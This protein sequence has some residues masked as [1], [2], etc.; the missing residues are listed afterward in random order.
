MQQPFLCLFIQYMPK[1]NEFANKVKNSSHV[2]TSTHDTG[3]ENVFA[4]AKVLGTIPEGTFKLNPKYQYCIVNAVGN[5]LDHEL[6]PIRIKDGD[7]LL[8]HE[9]PLDE[10][11]LLSTVRKVV[12][13]VLTD[14]RCFV[15]QMVFYDGISNGIRVR[16]FNPEEERFFVPI[17]KIKALFVVDEALSAE[18][19]NQL[20]KPIAGK[21]G[22]LGND[23]VEV[24]AQEKA[25]YL[26]AN[27]IEALKNIFPDEATYIEHVK[28]LWALREL[29]EKA[30]ELPNTKGLEYDT[31]SP[32]FRIVRLTNDIIGAILQ[33]DHHFAFDGE[34]IRHFNYGKH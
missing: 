24:P 11:S 28:T 5:C 33:G 6:S 32:Y 20:I 15:K 30:C 22:T 2:S 7:R 17:P 27:S 16:M 21:C 12:C 3:K 34:Q 14:G 31:N 23:L 18:Y 4:D 19:V 26:D 10:F 8:V 9:I 25:T 13:I 29:A 1:Y